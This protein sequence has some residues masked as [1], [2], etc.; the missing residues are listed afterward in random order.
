MSSAL[1]SNLPRLDLDEQKA[2]TPRQ[3]QM[4]LGK[5]PEDE[6]AVVVHEPIADEPPV[7]DVPVYVEPAPESNELEVLLE[8]LPEA[9]NQIAEEAQ[10][11]CIHLVRTISVQLFPALAESF[12]AEEIGQHLPALIPDFEPYI[13]VRLSVDLAKQMTEIISRNKRLSDRCRLM[14]CE[15]PGLAPIDISWSTGGVNFDFEALFDACLGRLGQSQ[16]SSEE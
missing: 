3:M 4:L 5:L 10:L 11:Q 8:A 15:S 12:L 16:P 1:W 9:L 6:V 13:E 2:M 7:E 14:P